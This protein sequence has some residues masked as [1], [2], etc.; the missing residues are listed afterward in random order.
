M[1]ALKN[2]SSPREILNIQKRRDFTKAVPQVYDIQQMS[3][4]ANLEKEFV[5]KARQLV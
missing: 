4:K 2:G 5:E 3:L 1:E